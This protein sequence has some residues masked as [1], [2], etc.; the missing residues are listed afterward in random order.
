[1]PDANHQGEPIKL[2]RFVPLGYIWD[3]RCFEFTDHGVVEVEGWSGDLGNG[4]TYDIR[5]GWD[6]EW[7]YEL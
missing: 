2:D 3:G 4:W 7:D 5:G 1:V 6:P